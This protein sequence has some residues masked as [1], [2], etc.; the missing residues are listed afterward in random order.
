M[1]MFESAGKIV[2]VMI[3]TM[4]IVEPHNLIQTPVGHAMVSI[5][6]PPARVYINWMSALS[7]LIIEKIYEL[8][9]H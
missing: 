3:L 4:I 9:F 5:S 6:P 1:V 7:R 8:Y 2:I